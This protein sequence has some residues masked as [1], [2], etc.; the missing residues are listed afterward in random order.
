[1]GSIKARLAGE[2]IVES[3]GNK[4][5]VTLGQVL[6]E[7]GYADNTADT[8]KNVTENKSYKEVT[9]PFIQKL[10]KERDRIVLEMSVRDLDEVQ[11][12]HL[13]SA[14][15]TLTKNIQL[16]GGRETEKMGVTIEVVSY[17]GNNPTQISTS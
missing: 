5:P 9:E 17:E 6:R 4:K 14:V 3:L 11:Y 15:D 16:L 10:E 1:M 2:K 8:P 7:V 13:T 12:Q